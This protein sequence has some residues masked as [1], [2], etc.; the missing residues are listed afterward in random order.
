MHFNK[1][2]NVI[3]IVDLIIGVL[4]E[5]ILCIIIINEIKYNKRMD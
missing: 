5:N 2:F 3:I 1:H 4:T